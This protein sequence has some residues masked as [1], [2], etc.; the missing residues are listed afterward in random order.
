MIIRAV[1]FDFFGTLVEAKAEIERCIGGMCQKLCQHQ[2]NVS[3]EEFTPVYREAALHYRQVRHSTHREV[4][5]CVWVATALQRLG[6]EV[7]PTSQPIAEAVDAYFSPWVL[8]VYEDVWPVIPTLRRRFRIG[9]ISNFTD[10]G[11]LRGSL[12]RLGLGKLFDCVLVSDEVGH[13]KPHPI[14]F[15]RF[16]R[17]L[18]VKA[19]EALFVGDDLEL[20]ILGAKGVGM[21]TAWIA[22]SGDQTPPGEPHAAQPDFIIRSLRDLN[23]ILQPQSDEA[24][25]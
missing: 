16:L 3:P 2:I 24:I 12:R 6:Y 20:D 19:E 4:N 18:K 23:H 7:E 15:N 1:G 10:T 17:A 8:T 25:I 5:N 11:F 9:V 22:R 13:R 21:K 14:I